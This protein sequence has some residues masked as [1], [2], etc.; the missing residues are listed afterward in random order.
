MLSPS[1]GI[2]IV[3]QITYG[4]SSVFLIAS[5][6]EWLYIFDFVYS[7]LLNIIPLTNVNQGIFH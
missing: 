1:S 5:V 6:T 7:K 3:P 2:Q 4:Q